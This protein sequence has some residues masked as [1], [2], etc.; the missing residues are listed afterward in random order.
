MH[1]THS[2]K[3]Q[4]GRYDFY[5][6]RRLTKTVMEFP[7]PDMRESLENDFSTLRFFPTKEELGLGDDPRLF[8]LID[9]LKAQII[10][11]VL[12]LGLDVTPWLTHNESIYILPQ[13]IYSQYCD[14]K[15]SFG[16]QHHNELAVKEFAPG[17][18]DE[19]IGLFDIRHELIHSVT[20][21]KILFYE[22]KEN[23]VRFIQISHGF[24]TG[25]NN[26]TRYMSYF[27][28]ALT[29]LLNIDISLTFED[30]YLFRI[31]YPQ[32]VAFVN[33]LAKD[34]AKRMRKDPNLGKKLQIKIDPNPKIT[35]NDVLAQFYIGMLKGD[36]R[37]LK[38]ISDLYDRREE[39]KK[40]FNALR[41]LAF[42][43]ENIED[44]SELARAFGLEKETEEQFRIWFSMA[45]T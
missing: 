35:T 34:I 10:S 43:G 45:R 23:A 6:H 1:I 7:D 3:K 9:S 21:C 26:N 2:L 40:T 39:G 11:F 13:D 33:A 29:E 12:K 5:H 31:D 14:D 16:F 25:R 17:F 36:R 20:C 41:A 37:Y 19:T 28:E 27:F 32:H 8:N 18:P 24:L 22:I 38:I 44:V 30:Q 42:M 15:N 4:V